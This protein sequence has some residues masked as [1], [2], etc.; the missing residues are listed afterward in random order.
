M[1]GW[2]TRRLKLAHASAVQVLRTLSTTFIMSALL[3]GKFGLEY[4]LRARPGNAQQ[5]ASCKLCCY[6]RYSRTVNTAE[7]FGGLVLHA[8]ES[9]LAEAGLKR[10]GCVLA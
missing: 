5:R 9:A 8:A 4:C 7:L 1:T 10:L 3:L 6:R 2:L